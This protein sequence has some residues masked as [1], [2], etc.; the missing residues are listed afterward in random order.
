MHVPFRRRLAAAC[1]GMA[2]LVA[3]G[4]AA[5]GTGQVGN[6][7][8]TVP[9]VAPTPEPVRLDP[10]KGLYL[11]LGDSYAAGTNPRSYSSGETSDFAFPNQIASR[12]DA[13]GT[14]LQLVNLACSG[15]TSQDMV[16]AAGC[17]SNLMGADST[18]YPTE[19][20]LAAAERVLTA[21]AGNVRLVTVVIGGNDLTR[22]LSDTHAS[23][24]FRTNPATTA[25]LQTATETLRDNLTE[26]LA[27]VRALVGPEVPVVGL[28]YPDSYLGLYTRT[29]PG[30]RDYAR[31]SQ[32]LFET[33]LNP[34]LARAYAAAGA[35]FVDITRL[36][37]GYDALDPTPDGTIPPPVQTVCLLTYMCSDEDVHATEAGHTFIADQVL[38]LAPLG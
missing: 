13:T 10:G 36:T 4:C 29:E 14:P 8:S 28:T 23:G 18:P 37:G 17:A 3:S 20:Q 19:P 6:T 2:L 35:E 25:C 21:S 26:I 30:Y 1:G 15:A 5:A 34:V 22:C 24:D 7:A 27:R 38:A 12:V 16:G 33:Q 9:V 31:A 32:Q 11:S